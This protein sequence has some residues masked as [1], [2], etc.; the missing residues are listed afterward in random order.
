MECQELLIEMQQHLWIHRRCIVAP[1]AT[2]PFGSKAL[3]PADRLT[4][5]DP[6]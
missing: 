4:V 1:S 6:E 5:F 3:T 2:I